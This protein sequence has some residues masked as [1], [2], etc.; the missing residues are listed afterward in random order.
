MFRPIPDDADSNRAL[1]DSEQ[2][3]EEIETELEDVPDS[4]RIDEADAESRLD[5]EPDEQR[6]VTD[7]EYNPADDAPA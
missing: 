5:K 2:I 4:E 3:D 7:P 1:A 6:S